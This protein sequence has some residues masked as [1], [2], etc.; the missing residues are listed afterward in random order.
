MR[1]RSE[2]LTR[3]GLALIALCGLLFVGGSGL[4]A[5]QAVGSQAGCPSCELQLDTVAFLGGEDAIGPFD[6]AWGVASDALQRFWVTF[7]SSA[8]VHVF[9]KSGNL[10][11]TVGTRGDGPGEVRHPL[12]VVP[13]GDSVALFDAGLQRVTIF[14]PDFDVVRT[15]SLPGQFFSGLVIEWPYVAMNGQVNSPRSVGHSLH[16][17]DLSSGRLIRSF[18]GPGANYAPH[19]RE[20]LIAQLIEGDD[21]SHFWSIS[22]TD[23]RIE[24]WTI[25]GEQVQV[26]TP[27]LD[28]FPQ[29]GR[30]RL[31]SPDVPPEPV[32]SGAARSGDTLFIAVQQPRR[33]W[34]RAWAALPQDPGPHPTI[35]TLPSL[36]R[37]YHLRI[38]AI[39]LSEA[40]MITVGDAELAF[41]PFV[42][43]PGFLVGSDSFGEVLF[44]GLWIVRPRVATHR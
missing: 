24:R 12:A 39:D 16:I 5:Q 21:S 4:Q 35:R 18:G 31:G 23:L 22:R 2:R 7:G 19:D 11:A 9:S 42:R 26:V 14:G 27:T 25:T 34:R 17:L 1:P 3:W 44:P 13:V 10:E 6:Q 28:W 40:S 37:L 36:P 8:P 29:G 33:D 20:R 41:R 30:G 38:L 32:V 43:T 15:L